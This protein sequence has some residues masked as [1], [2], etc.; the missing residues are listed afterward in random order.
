[1]VWAVGPNPVY[2]VIAAV[3]LSLPHEMMGLWFRVQGFRVD[4]TSVAPVLLHRRDER[5]ATPWHDPK[6]KP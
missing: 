6:P 2:R 3:C 5:C 4:G 1:V